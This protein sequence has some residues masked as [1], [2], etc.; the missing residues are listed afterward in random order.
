MWARKSARLTT[1]PRTYITPE[2]AAWLE[3][4]MAWRMFGGKD[5]F[6]L[7]AREAEAFAIL[8]SEMR[9]EEHGQG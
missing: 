6:E 2:S 1:C 9:K 4:Y 7:P 8:E 3:R 5:V